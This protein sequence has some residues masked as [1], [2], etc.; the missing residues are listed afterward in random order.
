MPAPL[1]STLGAFVAAIGREGA[2]ADARAAAVTGFIDT[3]ATTIAGR[4]EP[5][6]QVLLEASRPLPA[7]RAP[8]FFGEQATDASTAALLNGTAA[9]ALDYDDVALRGHPSA[10]LVSTILALGAQ[11]GACGADMLD[12][13]VAGYEVWADLVD[14]ETDI[15]HVKGW[16]PTGIFGAIGASAAASVLL[17]LDAGQCAHALGLGASQ[18]AG[19]MSNF[20]AMA[21]PFHVGRA[22]QAGVLAAR[23]AKAGFTA[24]ADALE[25]PQGFL[26]AVSPQGR[27][28]RERPAAAGRP[29][30][31]ADRRANVKRYPLCYYTHRALDGMLALRVRHGVQADQVAQVE[32]RMSQEHATVLRNHRPTTGLAAKFSIEF[33]MASALCNGRAGLAELGDA[34]VQAPGVQRLIERVTVIPI[35]ADDPQTPGAAYADQ[36]FVTLRDGSRLE[37]E[38]VHQALGHARRP[39]D[40]TQLR[41]KFS[42]ALAYGGHVGDAAALFE[43]LAGL[44]CQERVFA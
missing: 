1:T 30:Q 41:A 36:V 16:H 19:V 15:H 32:V 39:L 24:S 27:V 10:V 5:A 25:H 34:C 3:C 35:P 9:H 8:L 38:P 12:A 33:A 37:G 7:G 43:R 4:R 31:I 29:F 20:G 14:R 26:A 17:R 21:K 2:P 40:R 44:D 42:D 18:S 22:A 28:D 13:Y 11:T 23:L 6:V